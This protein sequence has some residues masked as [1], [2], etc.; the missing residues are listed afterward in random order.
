MG[1][2]IAGESDQAEQGPMKSGGDWSE[3]MGYVD[4]WQKSLLDREKGNRTLL[5]WMSTSE[6]VQEVRW[7]L[8]E[9]FELRNGR[10]WWRLKMI[11]LAERQADSLS[12]AASKEEKK[13]DQLGGCWEATAT[14][15]SWDNDD[16][17]LEF[18]W[19][20]F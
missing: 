20:L 5:V 16:L 4:N 1:V 9:A 17:G 3:E 6:K 11:I 10:P 13:G 19:S 18:Y 15:L 2:W 8:M 12:P 7:G 14:V